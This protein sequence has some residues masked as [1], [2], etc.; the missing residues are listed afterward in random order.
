MGGKSK[1]KLKF[2]EEKHVGQIQTGR[3]KAWNVQPFSLPSQ[4]ENWLSMVAVNFSLLNTSKLVDMLKANSH[5]L[6]YILNNMK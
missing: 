2:V 3:Q 6:G 1:K 5:F 4:F